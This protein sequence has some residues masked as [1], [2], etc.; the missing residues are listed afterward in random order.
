[1]PANLRSARERIHDRT[2]LYDVSLQKGLALDWASMESFAFDTRPRIFTSDA[3]DLVC[4][5]SSA[6]DYD[7]SLY[8]CFPSGSRF[9]ISS[10][11][12]IGALVSL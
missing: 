3:G 2:A 9:S 7:S 4:V 10:N 5:G 11:A 6:F 8:N 1:M 12:S